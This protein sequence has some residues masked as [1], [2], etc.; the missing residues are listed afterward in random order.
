V[1]D[2]LGETTNTSFIAHAPGT[3][4]WVVTYSGDATHKRASSGC[5]VERFTL[6]NS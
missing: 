2:G 3:W 4:R 5:G 6:T 1:S